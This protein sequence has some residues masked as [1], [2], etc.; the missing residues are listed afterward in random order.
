MN[1]NENWF[2][3]SFTYTFNENIDK[4]YNCFT[5]FRIFTEVV[6]VGSISNFKMNTTN[7]LDKKEVEFEYTWKNS[8][9]CKNEN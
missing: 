5:N 1:K 4:V 7:T 2:S 3:K 6:L 9:T 8:F